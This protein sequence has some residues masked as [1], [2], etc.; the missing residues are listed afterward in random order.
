MVPLSILDLIP[1]GRGS[2]A[3]SAL[4]ASLALARRADALG[5]TRYW[6]AEH[7]NTTGLACSAPEILIALIGQATQ[8]IR[9]G[10][11]GVMLPNHS[12][13]KIAET[14]RT[15]EALYPGRID[16]GVGRAPGTDQLTA[17]ALRRSTARLAADDFP[18]Q[19]QEVLAY[20]GEAPFPP[21]I[22]FESVTATPDGVPLPP[23]WLLSSS[24][25][26]ARLAAQL[27][28]AFAFAHH[29]SPEAAAESMRDY[30]ERFRPSKHLARPHAILT[31]SAVCAETEQRAAELAR[32]VE[33]MWIRIRR[34]ERGPLPLPE[35]AAAY[36]YTAL[37][38]EQARAARATMTVG[39]PEQ[40][41]RGL[42]ALVEEHRADELMIATQIGVAAERQRSYELIAEAFG[43]A[44]R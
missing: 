20:C 6:L 5:F 15:L 18:E 35:E 14:F 9:V 31:V 40:V 24:G 1:V 12:P 21:E 27:G 34:G 17:L 7:H 39:T 8:R 36:R 42:L 43:L 32:C 41:K 29:F 26:G 28:R 16:L 22:P 37:E 11:G 2:N 25:F 23:V 38:E 44:V 4:Q 13:L 10:S 3:S 30:R 19:L 33:L